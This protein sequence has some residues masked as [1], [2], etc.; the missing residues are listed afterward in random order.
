LYKIIN[1]LPAE[2]GQLI[3]DVVVT[4]IVLNEL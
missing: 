2:H 4:E 3:H 1:K